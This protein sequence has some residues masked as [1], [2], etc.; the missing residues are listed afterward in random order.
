ME[1][2]LRYRDSLNDVEQARLTVLLHALLDEHGMYEDGW[3]NEHWPQHLLAEARLKEDWEMFLEALH[4]NFAVPQELK[5]DYDML[6]ERILAI[7]EHSDEAIGPPRGRSAFKFTRQ[8][9]CATRSEVLEGERELLQYVWN[10]KVAAIL[11][12]DGLTDR[13]EVVRLAERL[14]QHDFDRLESD[15]SPRWPQDGI[16]RIPSSARCSEE[17]SEIDEI[18]VAKRLGFADSSLGFGEN[19]N[20]HSYLGDGSFGR[21]VLWVK[22]DANHSITDVC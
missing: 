8:A 18:E 22:Y 5:D 2:A 14:R 20:Y 4:S 12:N 7:F 9:F 15:L 21:A 3:R 11:A 1:A 16:L 19:W 13:D 17:N 10:G 6:Y